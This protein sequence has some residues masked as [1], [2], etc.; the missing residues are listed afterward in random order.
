MWNNESLSYRFDPFN[1]FQSGHKISSTSRWIVRR[2][3]KGGAQKIHSHA[4][5]LK[6]AE[7]WYILSLMSTFIPKW[8]PWK[9]SF[10]TRIYLIRIL[11][12]WEISK[13]FWEPACLD[14]THWRPRVFTE[15]IFTCWRSVKCNKNYLSEKVSNL[16]IVVRI[17]WPQFSRKITILKP[18]NG[19]QCS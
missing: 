19:K 17:F 7:F 6:N 3:W 9:P 5:S 13:N 1:G 10:L 8:L 2:K 11:R 14:C 15:C 16:G 12:G 4:M 18:G